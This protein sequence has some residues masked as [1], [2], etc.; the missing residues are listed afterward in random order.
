MIPEDQKNDIIERL[1][2]G[3][4]QLTEKYRRVMATKIEAEHL[5]LSQREEIDSLKKRLEDVSARYDKL[6]TARS[7]VLSD[8]DVKSARSRVNKLVREIDKCISLL[9]E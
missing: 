1:R 7:F 9:N 6:I 4:S 8:G 3:V 5:V 2:N